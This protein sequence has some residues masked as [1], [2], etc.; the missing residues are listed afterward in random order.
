MTILELG[1]G[2]PGLHPST[3]CEEILC[4]VRVPCF[5]NYETKPR[6][7]LFSMDGHR[8]KGLTGLGRRLRIG[9]TR[10]PKTQISYWPIFPE[11]RLVKAAASLSA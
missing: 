5:A 7:T 8:Q 3:L 9:S 2:H 6:S 11:L 10:I 1:T 4:A